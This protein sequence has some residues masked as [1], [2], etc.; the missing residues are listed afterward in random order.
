M[1]LSLLV[2][3]LVSLVCLHYIVSMKIH[4]CLFVCQTLSLS[5]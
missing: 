1:F 5:F 4:I 2:L 3:D